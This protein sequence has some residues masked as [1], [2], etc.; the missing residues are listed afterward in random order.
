MHTRGPKNFGRCWGHTAFGW[1]HGWHHRNMLLPCVI[2]PNFIAIG[3]TV[4]AYIYGSPKKFGDASPRRLGSGAW[5]TPRNMLLCHVCY[6]TKFCHPPY[7]EHPLREGSPYNCVEWCPYQNVKKVWRFVHSFWHSIGTGQTDR[8]TD[9]GMPSRDK[10][11]CSE[12]EWLTLVWLV[13]SRVFTIRKQ[14]ASMIWVRSLF[15]RHSEYGA[16]NL[17]MAELKRKR[18]RRV[19]RFHLSTHLT[20]ED[21]DKL[22][23]VVK[24]NRN[25]VSSSRYRLLMPAHTRLD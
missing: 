25:I 19:P 17:L 20:V 22:L 16:Y 12:L 3:K 5:L 8:H 2:I 15:W 24:G 21:F 7:I 4:L 13:A 14:K 9:T 1:G 23:S 11:C 18:H 6:H 10:N